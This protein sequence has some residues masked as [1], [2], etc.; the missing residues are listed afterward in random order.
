MLEY[1]DPESKDGSD[2]RTQFER[3]K[4][5]PAIVVTGPHRSG[6]TFAAEARPRSGISG[7]A[8]G[9]FRLQGILQTDV[10]PFL[11]P[12]RTPADRR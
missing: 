8:G 7:R 10:D 4:A 2:Y 3:L 12:R 9:A 1:A 6:T 11:N 5:F